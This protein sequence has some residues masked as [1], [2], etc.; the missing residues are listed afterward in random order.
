MLWAQLLVGLRFWF[1]MWVRP[2]KWWMSKPNYDSVGFKGVR[3]CASTSFLDKKWAKLIRLIHAWI[4][5]GLFYLH[6]L[7]GSHINR[8]TYVFYWRNKCIFKLFFPFSQAPLNVQCNQS[9]FEI[10]NHNSNFSEDVTMFVWFN[11][12]QFIYKKI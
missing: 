1:E 6:S 3:T 9:N 4:D 8:R 10:T 5:K 2:K 12:Y 11:F 7:F